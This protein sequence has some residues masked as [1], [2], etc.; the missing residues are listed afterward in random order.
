MK[1]RFIVTI[2]LFFVFQL[3][4]QSDADPQSNIN[5]A[6]LKAM[7][8]INSQDCLNQV[9]VLS[10]EPYNGR[11]AGSSD[12]RR[13]ADYIAD[14]FQRAGLECAAGS[15]FFQSFF[16]NRNIID[17]D[18]ELALEVIIRSNDIVDTLWI[19]YEFEKDYL[20]AGFSAD[21]SMISD[22]VLVGYGITSENNYWDD[23]KNA[24]IKDKI[25]LVLGGTP[26][27]EEVQWGQSARMSQKVNFALH[28]GAAGF[29]GIGGPHASIYTEQKVPALFISEKV[30]D[31]MLSGT[32]YTVNKLKKEI[33]FD[34]KSKS[35]QLVHR[36]KLKISSELKVNAETMNIVGYLEGSDEKLK[37]EY[38]IIGAHADHIGPLGDGVFYGANDNASGTAVLLETAKAFARLFPRPRRSLVFIA[39]TGEEMGLMGSKY[40]TEHP[41]FPLEKTKAMI[42]LDMVGSGLDGITI[43]GGET[44]TNFY[45]ILEQT[46]NRY[47]HMSIEKMKITENSDH[48]PFYQKGIPAVF[49]LTKGGPSTWHSTNDVVEY[50][51]GEAMEIVGRYVFL[52][53]WE[54]ANREKL[55]L[56]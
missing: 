6:V 5:P 34:Q 31:D 22:A 44:F 17:P 23:Y 7:R 2:I 42:N 38:I 53:V 50:V 49:L 4:S 30:A 37:N 55:N 26:K 41:L 3:Y 51:N 16:V 39:F 8:W 56:F 43:M 24:E 28:H 18:N 33:N 54:I 21:T 29:I 19:Y 36:I 27:I 48:Y 9:R 40:Y 45:Y 47:I 52:S 20:P 35:V 12:F 14:E 25:V 15:D 10:G 1:K 13:V 32:G 11:A 46:N